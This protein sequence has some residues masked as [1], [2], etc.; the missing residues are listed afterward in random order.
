LRDNFNALSAA[1]SNKAD[2]ETPS[3]Q[4]DTG[5][6]GQHS[7]LNCPGHTVGGF[8]WQLDPL[9]SYTKLLARWRLILS[10]T[11][12]YKNV[13]EFIASLLLEK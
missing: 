8:L 12:S 5:Y 11:P 9:N 1:V 13:T 3:P 7:F 6:L 10:H 2:A 4:V